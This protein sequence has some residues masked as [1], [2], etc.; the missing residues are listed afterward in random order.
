MST[1]LSVENRK[2]NDAWRFGFIWK[3]LNEGTDFCDNFFSAWR[4]VLRTFG[5]KIIGKSFKNFCQ[6]YC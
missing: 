4:G 3:P 5:G 2:K 6:K 1:P